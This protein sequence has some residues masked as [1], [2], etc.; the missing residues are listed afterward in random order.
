MENNYIKNTYKYGRLATL[1]AMALM[2]GI[3]AVICTV[4]GIWPT[5][6]QVFAAAGPLLAMFIPVAVS[7]NISMIPIQGTSVYLNSILGNVMNIKF[8]CYLNTI[9][10]VGATPGT[11]LAD[12]LGMCAVTVSGMVSIIVIAIGLFLMVPLEPILTSPTVTTA[13]AYIMPALYGSMGISAFL[14]KSAGSYKAEGKIWLAVIGVALILFVH[15]FIT[16]V[17]G[18]EGYAMLI[19]LIFISLLSRFLLNKGIIKLHE[20]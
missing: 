4:Y 10:K 9:Q 2:L 12:A 1:I 15:Y 14:S 17:K 8:P 18:K 7:E 13:T 6:G 19:M 20:K 11:E 16:P 5:P 3:P